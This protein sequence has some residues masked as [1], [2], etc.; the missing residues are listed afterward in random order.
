MSE[1]KAGGVQS[2]TINRPLLSLVGVVLAIADHG[3][4]C[5]RELCADLVLQACNECDA[6]ESGI[7]EAPLHGVT[8][9]G[10]RGRWVFDGAQALDHAL[11]P[12][13]MHECSGVVINTAT[14]QR[15]I[16]AYG[17]MVEKLADEHFA[18]A[19][20]FRKQQDS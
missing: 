8:Q 14:D 18:V 5:D 17:K 2:D 20:R 11:A 7:R 12:E 15:Q 13:K 10:T 1:A 9:F 19:R 3:M 16:L 4:T 6:H